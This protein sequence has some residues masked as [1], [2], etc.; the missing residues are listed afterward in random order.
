[1]AIPEQ[2][3]GL[4]QARRQTL[5]A[6]EGLS[7][8]QLDWSP[9]PRR[10]SVGEVLDHLARV[11]AT[12]RGEIAELV[13]RSRAGE[14]AYLR[15]GFSD[16]DVSVFHLPKALLPLLDLPFTLASRLL[17]RAV[18]VWMAT[19]RLVP[20]QH[21]ES[22]TPE[23]GR[24]GAA[25]RAA[26]ERSLAGFESI[27]AAAPDLDYHQLVHQHPLFGVNDVTQL[28]EIATAHERRHQA[29]IR[30]LVA[31]PGFPAGGGPPTGE[32][33]EETGR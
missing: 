18:G 3:D 28:L 23:P 21:P 6:V 31:A 13:R 15:R 20:I 11:D 32:G 17:P 27:F 4:R 12:Y 8:R 14:R 24:P 26:L 33:A 30:D 5:E 22:A 7:L 10:W 19:S 29:Q 1:M 2:L 25:L 9:A 16:I